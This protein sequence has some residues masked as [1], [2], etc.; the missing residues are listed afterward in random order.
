LE[1]SDIG[2]WFAWPSRFFAVGLSM[3]Q[4]I[5][6]AGRR[7]AVSEQA[8]AAYDA[9]VASYR[10]SVLA[11]FQDVED[12]LAALRILN[13]EAQEQAA[14]KSAERSVELATDRYKGG[15]ASYLEVTT[16]QAAAL[17]NQ[18]A[19]VDIQTRRMTASVLL[20][21]ALGGGWNV[22]SLPSA[23]ELKSPPKTS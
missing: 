5:F 4:T 19:A 17:A 13:Q 14:V 20:I 10:E 23:K 15:I 16:A 22:S 18:R 8:Q 6:D 11:A 21:K 9:T 2:S 3:V 12:N 1:S 7:R